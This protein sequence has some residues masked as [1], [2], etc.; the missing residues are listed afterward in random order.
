M[1][2]TDLQFRSPRERTP[3]SYT[4]IATK[5]GDS[6][7]NTAINNDESSKN[8]KQLLNFLRYNK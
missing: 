5:T 6:L 8:P 2:P 4:I 3:G 7:F 1:R